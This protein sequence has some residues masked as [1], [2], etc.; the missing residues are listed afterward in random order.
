MV[1]KFVTD[2]FREYMYHNK[3]AMKILVCH[4]G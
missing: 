1:L 4:A 3:Y 2:F